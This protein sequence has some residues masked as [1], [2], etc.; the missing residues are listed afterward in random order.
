[1]RGA[2]L[3]AAGD[4]AAALRRAAS[5]MPKGRGLDEDMWRRRHDVIVSVLWVTAGGLCVFG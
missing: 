5:L 1:M 4:P 2:L 3:A